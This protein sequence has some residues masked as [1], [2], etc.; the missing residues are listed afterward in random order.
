MRRAVF[1]FR[2]DI[3]LTESAIANDCSEL[4]FNLTVC[5][6]R[7]S[8]ANVLVFLISNHSAIAITEKLSV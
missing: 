1:S 4:V 3:G 7:S 2:N 6:F 8:S 5:P